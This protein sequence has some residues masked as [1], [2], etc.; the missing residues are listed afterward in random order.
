MSVLVNGRTDASIDAL[1][2]GLQY[3]DGLFE[4][5]AAPCGRPRFLDRHFE[6]LAQG[7]SRLDLHLPDLTL[8]RDELLSLC[9]SGRDAVLKL[10]VTRGAGERGYRPQATAAPTRILVASSWPDRPRALW[11]DG[12]RLGWCRTRLGRNPALAGIKH[13]NR[14]EQVLARAEWDDERMDEGL[15]QD[16]QDLVVS[17]TQA[18]LFARIDG[19]WVTPSLTHCGVAGIMRRAFIE[20]SAG[21]GE[22]V[23]ERALPA[24][25]LGSATALLLTNA[26]IG[27]WPVRQLGGRPLAVDAA[28]ARFNAWLAQR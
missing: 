25:E 12:V 4:T 16:E 15:M 11:T 9:D 2:R 14:L 21:A 24:A 6:R 7:A 27:A 3:G 28:A 23:G 8:M 20:W 22:P 17:A 10:I 19:R 18:N 13:L 26:L 5:I 1:D